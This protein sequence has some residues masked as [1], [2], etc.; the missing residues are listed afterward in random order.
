[1]SNSLVLGISIDNQWIRTVVVTTSWQ[2]EVY[3]TSQKTPQTLPELLQ[4]VEVLVRNIEWGYGRPNAIGLS[5]S[6]EFYQRDGNNVLI[7]D[8]I[9]NDVNQKT[10]IECNV[11]Q[12]AYSALLVKR[13]M[14]PTTSNESVLSTVID[15]HCSIVFVDDEH[16]ARKNRLFEWAHSRLPEYHWLIDGLS[17]VC[18]CGKEACLD[19][20][21]TVQGIER[22]Y[23][24]VVLKDCTLAE[25][26]QLVEAS[27]HHATR[28]YRA[29]V[30]QLARALIAPIQ[31]LMPAT[32]QLFGAASRYRFLGEDLKVALSRYCEPSIIPEIKHDIDNTS[33]SDEFVFALGATLLPCLIRSG[34]LS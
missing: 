3:R 2:D 17:P 18:H 29:F 7:S 12:S 15:A 9:A 11:I 22:Q 13:Q 5:V 28:I 33:L 8:T 19:Q 31:S 25:I 24:Q 14:M 1:M 23:H 26:Y 21:L 32:L 6:E 20:F 27:D 16:A 4:A 34:A 10:G 30:D